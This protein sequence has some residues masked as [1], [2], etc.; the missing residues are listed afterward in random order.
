MLDLYSPV[1]LAMKE[2]EQI[3]RSKAICPLSLSHSLRSFVV[4]VYFFFF[5]FLPLRPGCNSLPAR[6]IRSQV[7]FQFFCTLK[8]RLHHTCSCF[9]SSSCSSCSLMT[10]FHSRFPLSLCTCTGGTRRHTDT[11]LQ[12]LYLSV[13]RFTLSLF[14]KYYTIVFTITP[15]LCFSLSLRSVLSFLAT[16]LMQSDKK[17]TRSKSCRG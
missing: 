14:H 6:K 1:T 13:N 9:S 15:T 4:V 16:L 7:F 3:T 17:D 12:Q 10:L 5:F 2:S 11:E 8:L